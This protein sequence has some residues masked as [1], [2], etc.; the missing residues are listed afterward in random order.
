MQDALGHNA[1]VPPQ[2]S[3]RYGWPSPNDVRLTGRTRGLFDE[4]EVRVPN[5][6]VISPTETASM[7]A[8][9]LI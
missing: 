3:R 9:G 1:G 6:I 7:A 8:C 4:I 2:P 5:P